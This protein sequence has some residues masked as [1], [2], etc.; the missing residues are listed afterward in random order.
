MVSRP[1][2]VATQGVSEGFTL[3]NQPKNG[4]PEKVLR[5]VSQ[6]I[7]WARNA[8]KP[9]EREWEQALN[10]Y[11]GRQWGGAK[12]AI[13]SPVV[14]NKFW[15]MI[16]AALGTYFYQN[17]RVYVTPITKWA[18]GTDPLGNPLRVDAEANSRSAEAAVDTM[19]RTGEQKYEVRSCIV[20]ANIYSLGIMKVGYSS[21]AGVP[22]EDEIKAQITPEAMKIMQGAVPGLTEHDFL[23]ISGKGH[24]LD[25]DTNI[26]PGHA[27]A[28]RVNPMDVWFD[29]EADKQRNCRF[30]IHRWKAQIRTLKQD[31]L[32]GN[33]QGLEPEDGGETITDDSFRIPGMRSNM[34]ASP[35]ES[36]AAD[37]DPVRSVWVWEYYDKERQKVYWLVH[38]PPSKSKRNGWRVIR[39][40]HEW[41]YENLADFPFV[42]LGLNV[43][44]N[45]LYPLTGIQQWI[46]QQRELNIIRSVRLDHVRRQGRKV[47]MEQN[48]MDPEQKS[49]MGNPGAYSIIEVHPGHVD[50][51]RPLETGAV[52]VDMYRAEED[53]VRDIHSLMPG[54]LGSPTAQGIAQRPG[55]SATESGQIGSALGA[56]TADQLS[57]VSDFAGKI[58]KYQFMIFRQFWTQEDM[59]QR[60]S[61]ADGKEWVRISPNTLLGDFDYKVEV[62]STQ[63]QSAEVRQKRAVELMSMALNPMVVQLFGPPL[64]QKVFEFVLRAFDVA[65][66]EAFFEGAKETILPAE[67]AALE[68]QK[69][70][71]LLKGGGAPQDAGGE[72][73]ASGQPGPGQGEFQP[74]QSGGGPVS[75]LNALGGGATA[76][77]VQQGLRGAA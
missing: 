18:Y 5:E 13:D 46:A 48:A 69:M 20:D 44:P 52:P 1:E 9:Y 53:V 59:M 67:R 8:R 41:P 35:R 6:R 26:R 71:A 19:W 76:A 30:M 31:P 16:N 70:Q 7:D 28:K 62:G 63:Q 56:M 36:S 55:I 2:N 12:V 43:V 61:G 50:K 72:A 22:R 25:H 40:A 75:P 42:T 73:G 39:V 51:I 4:L 29:P 17:P 45:R 58:S 64:V 38:Q 21:P 33:L 54:G 60:R 15:P 68:I 24:L 57:L 47:L 10:Y 34:S 37:E 65:V 49:M 66:P 77:N 74:N 32:F 23:R 11:L 3:R 14:V 27:F